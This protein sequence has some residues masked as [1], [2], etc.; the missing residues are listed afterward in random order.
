MK[1]KSSLLP[2]VLLSI[3]IFAL[4]KAPGQTAWQALDTLKA[5]R[6][7]A[8]V[9]NVTQ[10]RGMK[11]Q[12][13][14]SAWEISTQAADGERV[15]VLERGKIVADTVYSAGGGVPIDMRRL[16]VDSGEAFVIA[17]R[18]ATESK[19]SFDSL[20]YEL[21]ASA[22]GNA[23]LWVIHLRDSNDKDVGELDVSGETG[24]VLRQ[25]YYHPRMASRLPIGPEPS[26]RR[27]VRSYPSSEPGAGAA[28]WQRTTAGVDGAADRV[29]E[30]FQTI[31]EG[32]G[33]LFK[34]ETTF[35]VKDSERIKKPK[36]LPSR[37]R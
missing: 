20:D 28:V 11:G 9:S 13:Q 21:S 1:R 35:E 8:A 34:G 18:V 26:S 27:V 19:V 3:L 23:P 5:T 16:R 4:S 17:N 12:D 10:L 14:P 24:E 7:A 15:Y 22:V 31:G 33:R 2:W 36:T 6:G 25:S 37:G 30:G 29:K 32:I